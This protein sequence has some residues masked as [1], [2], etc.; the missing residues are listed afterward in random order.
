MREQKKENTAVFGDVSYVNAS[1]REK[2]YEIGT[3]LMSCRV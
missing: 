2:A 1:R 3:L